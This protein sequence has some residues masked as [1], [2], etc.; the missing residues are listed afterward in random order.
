VNEVICSMLKIKFAIFP[1][2]I[3][4]MVF[5]PVALFACPG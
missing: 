3:A 2:L 4:I 1:L 5:S